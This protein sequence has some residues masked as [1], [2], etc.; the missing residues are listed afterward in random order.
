MGD[1]GPCGPCTEI[2]IDRTPDKT[3]GKLVNT[4]DATRSSRSG[5]SSSSSSTAT[6][7][8][9]LTPLPAKHVDTGMGFERDHGGAPGQGQQ[10]R[11]GRVHA[12][13]RGDPEGDEGAGRTRG[14]LD[15]LKDTAYRVIADHIRTLT[16]ALT[17]GGAARQ[18]GPR[19]RPASASCAGR[20][21]TAG[22]YLGTKRAVPARAR[23]GRRR[24]HGRRVPGAEARTRSK[25]ATIR[26][27]TRRRRSSAR[28][29]AASSCSTS[30]GGR[31][32]KRRRRR[33]SAATDAF[34]LHDTYGFFIDITEQMAA[35][36][37]LD[38]RSCR[39]TSR[40]WRR[41]RSKS[42]EGGKKLVVTA[43]QGE[44]P[45]TDDSPKYGPPIDHGEGPRL[46]EGQRRRPRRASSQATDDGRPAARPHQLL[47]RA[48]RPGRRHRP[49]PHA[50]GMTFEV[51]DTQRLGDSRPARRASLTD[52]HDQGR[53]DGR[54]CDGQRD[55]VDT[56]RNHTATHL[57]N[58]ALREVLGDH[59]EQK[60]SLVDA[61]KTRFDFTHDKPLTR[62]RD[63]A[64]SSGSS[65]SR[66]SATCR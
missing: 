61:E 60:G 42:R 58:L 14:K 49:H 3:G 7:T 25:V 27:A 11:H 10:L 54:R 47:R 21:A 9:S 23:A 39:A 45:K 33:S 1:T 62:R 43:V 50:D 66:S 48:G 28:S 13:L 55:R 37:G 6:R 46:G 22:R 8:R 29:T 36:A 24:A 12:A 38:G 57:L 35:E 19:L 17:D 2:H 5:T 59:V 32:R 15:D 30:V 4:G 34:N 64:R 56:M 53:P 41:P 51:E 44:L 16:F 31:E 26:S 20:S 52:G 40:R 65:T 63:R 18:R